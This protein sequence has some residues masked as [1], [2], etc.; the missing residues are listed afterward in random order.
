M[1]EKLPA[2][3]KRNLRKIPD[4]LRAKAEA[5]DDIDIVAATVKKIPRADLAAGKYGHLQLIT[6]GDE[7]TF[8]GR[9]VPDRRV[10]RYSRWNVEGR[11]VVHRDHPKVTRTY[12]WDAPNFGDES[13]GT[14]EVCQDRQVYPRD[15]IP[16][17]CTPISIECLASENTGEDT[18]YTFKFVVA[19]VL[20]RMEQDYERLLLITLN[21]LQENVGKADLFPSDASR[22]D[23]LATVHVNWEI[24]PEG[25]RDEEIERLIT[26]LH[27]HRPEQRAKLAARYTTLKGLGPYHLITGTNGFARYFGASFGDGLVVFE[28]LEYGN[29]IY[30]MFEGWQRLSQM[31]RLELRADTSA[32]FERI[33]HR[34]NWTARLKRIVEARRTPGESA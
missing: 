14:H 13:R 9:I 22:A 30:A 23:Y 8:P 1:T 27:A 21:L 15:F 33:E 4:A 10:G 19:R 34:G 17:E 5:L 26:K 11:E 12:C 28:N 24:L 6:T 25:S 32:E 7:V 16:S 29:A 20:H 3:W 2:P 18:I 31:T